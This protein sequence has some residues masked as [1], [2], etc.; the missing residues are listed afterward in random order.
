MRGGMSASQTVSVVILAYN[1]AEQ[2]TLFRFLNAPG[3]PA[4]IHFG[5]EQRV[6][7][8]ERLAGHASLTVD[9]KVV[10]GPQAE[11]QGRLIEIPISGVRQ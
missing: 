11:I 4:G 9:G 3:K 6:N 2:L 8:A 5:I 10:E 1:A 7:R